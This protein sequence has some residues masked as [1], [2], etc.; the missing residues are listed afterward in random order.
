MDEVGL[1][2]MIVFSVFPYSSLIHA[3][4]I[5]EEHKNILDGLMNK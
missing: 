3:G 1:D 2:N 5:A 4:V